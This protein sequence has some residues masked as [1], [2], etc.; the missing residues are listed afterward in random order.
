MVP[1]PKWLEKICQYTGYP[2]K[3]FLI[4]TGEKTDHPSD[5]LSSIFY[6]FHTTKFHN[7]QRYP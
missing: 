5:H 6:V 7:P 1:E 3:L 4:L 2:N